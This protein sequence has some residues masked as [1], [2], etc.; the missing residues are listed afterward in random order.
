[1]WFALGYTLHH[2]IALA[3]FFGFKFAVDINIF[4]GFDAFDPSIQNLQIFRHEN[5]FR[6]NFTYPDWVCFSS[7]ELIPFE[8]LAI[9]I[10]V[11]PLRTRSSRLLTREIR[12]RPQAI[13]NLKGGLKSHFKSTLI[14]FFGT[15]GVWGSKWYTHFIYPKYLKFIYPIYFLGI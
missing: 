3:I 4:R 5:N 6:R 2:S 7:R 11:T 14:Y 13:F 10:W 12:N 9:A 1:M 15:R 8:S